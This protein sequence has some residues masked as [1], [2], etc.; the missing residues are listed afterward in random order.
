METNAPEHRPSARD[1]CMRG[2]FML[3]MLIAFWVAETLLI[4][5]ALV[6][7]FWLLFARE[8][9]QSLARFGNP[10][11]RG[12][13]RSAGFSAARASKNRSRGH[14]GRR[15]GLD[16]ARESVA[17]SRSVEPPHAI[18]ETQGSR[19]KNGAGGHQAGPKRLRADGDDGAHQHSERGDVDE[20]G[21]CLSRDTQCRAHDDLPIVCPAP[22]SRHR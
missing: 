18:E 3:L 17:R 5:L 21:Q 13:G 11:Q 7:F 14:P 2:L 16:L 6:Q 20:C 4:L 10:F 1:I 8:P 12:F 22:E 9:N 19:A 15:R